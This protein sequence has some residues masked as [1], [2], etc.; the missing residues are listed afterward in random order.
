MQKFIFTFLL[1][2]LAAQAAICKEF[3]P[4]GTVKANDSLYVDVTEIRVLD[5]REYMYWNKKL[6][7]AESDE[8][9]QT[10][11][12]TTVWRTS[13]YE[14]VAKSYF[15]HPAYH[16]YPIV[17]ISFE[18]AVAYCEWRSQRVNYMIYIR[19]NKIPFQLTDDTTGVPQIYKYRLP[20][21]I[22]WEAIASI[23]FSEKTRK[24][25]AGKKN[26]NP[27]LFN[28][29]YPKAE[30][31]NAVNAMNLN[32][33]A[34]VRSFWPNELG[35]YNLIGNVAEMTAEKGLAKGG[36]WHHSSYDVVVERDFEYKGKQN[37]VGFR[38]V[39]EKVIKSEKEIAAD[40]I[41]LVKLQKQ[42]VADSIS[43]AK[44]LEKAEIEEMKL[45]DKEE[46]KLEKENEKKEEEED[47]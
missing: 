14:Q 42:F 10:I 37:W 41:K 1:I 16:E 19:E 4:P 31:K 7:G 26:F 2:I 35:C 15:N 11:P 30:G 18:Q 12:D 22:E 47:E 3:I 20:T 28:L 24:Q 33:T 21:K 9:K 45:Q 38:C 36:A 46:K 39:C 5:W 25:I 6:Y 27:N 8:Y 43:Q 32:V 34:V 17:G 44:A 40:S 13:I 23:S 29:I